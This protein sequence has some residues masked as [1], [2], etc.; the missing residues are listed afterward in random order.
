MLPLWTTITMVRRMCIVLLNAGKLEFTFSDCELAGAYSRVLRKQ[1]RYD[2][3]RIFLV[4][5]LRKTASKMPRPARALAKLSL[6][7]TEIDE[8]TYLFERRGRTKSQF[9]DEERG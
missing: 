4:D 3:G 5:L 9:S 1:Q 6:I 8:A 2:E 7:L